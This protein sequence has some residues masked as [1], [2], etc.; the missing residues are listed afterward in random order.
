MRRAHSVAS[1]LLLAALLVWAVAHGA[2]VAGKKLDEYRLA[3]PF[4]PNNA[5]QAGQ[6]LLTGS[7]A[8]MSDGVQLTSGPKQ[9]GSVW[10]PQVVG[11]ASWE[12]HIRFSVRG[13]S[14][15]GDNG[16]AFWYV[17]SPGEEGDLF[18]YRD[19]FRGLG[20][21]FDSKD[22]DRNHNNPSVAAHF[23]D[24]TRPFHHADD[25]IRDQLAGCV[26]DY[27]NRNEPVAARI[28]YNRG[29]KK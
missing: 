16:M 20:V 5:R 7:A 23:Y 1:G 14:G 8:V 15:E 4:D 13:S 22:N 24:G 27:R 12:V 3:P 10:H 9:R 28:T 18:G 21:I 2:D 6:W 19:M 17:N 25:G 11:F 26:A 29:A